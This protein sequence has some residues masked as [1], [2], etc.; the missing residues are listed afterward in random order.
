M[1][2]TTRHAIRTLAVIAL[3]ITGAQAATIALN[4]GSLEAGG[5]AWNIPNNFDDWSESGQ[6]GKAPVAH[7][8]SY[9]L[10]NCW[11]YGWN[12]LSQ[13]STYTVASV[14]ETISAFVWAKTD[15]NLGTE[16]AWFNLTLTLDNVGVAFAQP[17]YSGG[18]DWTELTASYVTTAADIGKTVGISFGT[19]GGPT[20]NQ[21]N[22]VYMDDASLSVIPE[23]SATVLGGLGV[24]ALL[25]RR[26]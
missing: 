20:N 12:S 11:G 2:T 7:T 23:P 14:G 6:T 21:P 17:N 26:R 1:K 5:S 8:G 19:D 25:R 3:G 24:L 9:G 15:G 18:Q 16:T 10:W 13:Q 22:Y 4:N